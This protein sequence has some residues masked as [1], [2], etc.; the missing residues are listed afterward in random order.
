MKKNDNVYLE[1]GFSYA[2]GFISAYALCYPHPYF[3][4]IVGAIIIEAILYIFYRRQMS[5]SEK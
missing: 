5:R 1:R 4:L 3:P 2:A